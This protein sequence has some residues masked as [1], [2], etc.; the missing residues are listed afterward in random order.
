[1][2]K[3]SIL[4]IL[5]VAAVFRLYGINNLSPPGLEHDEVAH[6]LINRSILAG[7]HAVYFTEAYGHEAGF[8]YVQTLFQALLG[9]HALALRLPAAFAGIIGVALSFALGR[10]LFGWRVGLIS[11]AFGAVLLWPVFFGRLALRAIALPLVAGASAYAWWRGWAEERGSGGAEGRRRL[12]GWQGRLAGRT[13]SKNPDLSLTTYHLPL[14]T[15]H[16]PL[17][18]FALAGV[19]AGLS[20]HTYMAARALPIFYG[21]FTVYL[22]LFHRPR[23]REMRRGIVFFWLLLGLVA[24][25]LVVYLLNNPQAEF[26]IAEVDAPLQALRGGDFGPV[27][28]N[29]LRIAGMFGFRGDPLW[30]QN[31]AGWPVFD[32]LL[33]LAFYGGVIICIWRWRD[34]RYA[35][36]LLWLAASAVPSIVTID[37]PSSIRIIMLLPVLMLFPAIFIHSLPKLSTAWE[38]LSTGGDSEEW[39]VKSGE[40]RWGEQVASSTSADDHLPPTVRHAPLTSDV[41]EYS[42]TIARHSPLIWLLLAG[43]FFFHGWRT[44]DALLRTWPENEEVQFVWQAALTEAAQ[45]LD[46]SAEAGPVAIGGW[47]PETMDPP[48]MELTLRRE[49]LSLRYFDPREGVILPKGIDN[50]QLSIVNCQLAESQSRI[51]RPEILAFHPLVEA[52][53]ESVGAQVEAG[54]GFMLYRLAEPVV[55][56]PQVPL[57]ATFGDEIQLLG[58][59]ES[60]VAESCTFLTYWQVLEAA[61][62]PRRIFLHAVDETG[63]I[64]SQDDGLGAPAA[65][66]Q[67]GDVILQVLEAPDSGRELEWRLGVYNPM[68]EER[69]HTETG[70][71]FVVLE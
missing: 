42:P 35:F 26:R 20:L 61:G 40:W 39:R 38:K 9:D 43:L 58:Y 66:W 54:E 2:K 23:F 1:M 68:T 14:V 3:V 6:W 25:P 17:A 57:D 34:A 18:W 46:E 19:L 71:D 36:L 47:T 37:A 32:P 45:Y 24:A 28:E 41:A 8:H 5:L 10:L 56:R 27:L 50:C 29:S 31:V 30:R 63:E 15:R 60:C 13:I 49:D 69:L 48:T 33:A 12:G 16:S 4:I 51:V 62:G 7:Q 65:Y 11:A 59:D 53:L 67:A 55:A 44:A 52:A 64:A 21:L 22:F 70:N